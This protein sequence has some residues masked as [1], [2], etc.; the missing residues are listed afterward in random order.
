MA[1]APDP[2]NKFRK[3]T[4][5][6]GLVSAAL[7]LAYVSGA[8][9]YG[10]LA[11]H[12]IWSEIKTW[13]FALIVSGAFFVFFANHVGKE[14]ERKLVEIRRDISWALF[15]IGRFLERMAVSL[16]KPKS[17]WHT[18]PGSKV[19]RKVFVTALIIV[20]TCSETAQEQPGLPEPQRLAESNPRLAREMFSTHLMGPPQTLEQ[21]KL[22]PVPHTEKIPT[23]RPRPVPTNRLQLAQRHTTPSRVTIRHPLRTHP[24]QEGPDG[25]TVDAYASLNRWVCNPFTPLFRSPAEQLYCGFNSFGPPLPPTTSTDAIH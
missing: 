25:P 10:I 21:P 1:S 22:V 16:N 3:S 23:P 15:S 13:W 12:T 5:L 19:A 2:D 14:L 4:L 6:V 11:A 24:E 20:A 9:A 18:I 7:A 8:I 17:N